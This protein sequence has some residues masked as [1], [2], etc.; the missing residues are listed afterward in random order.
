M[1]DFINLVTNPS[2]YISLAI[3]AASLLIIY[4]IKNNKYLK[5]KNGNYEATF[6][7]EN[8]ETKS[9][10]DEERLKKDILKETMNIQLLLTKWKEDN[11]KEIKQ[12]IDNSFSQQIKFAVMSIDSFISN[13]VN[14]AYAVIIL[15]RITSSAS[16][17]DKILDS[18]RT[19]L[20]DL[21]TREIGKDMK[22]II[23][24]EIRADHFNTRLKEDFDQLV[25]KVLTI[26]TTKLS[27]YSQKLDSEAL[28][29]ITQ[30]AIPE[31]KILINTIL[32]H[33]KK[34]SIETDA[35]VKT[36]KELARNELTMKVK[37]QFPDIEEELVNIIID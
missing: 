4:M 29:K 7:S 36:A 20:M 1:N 33:S 15:D 12:I 22:D 30:K 11:E 25:S 14:E 26:F 27:K 8:R 19:A 28:T 2:F 24:T 9:L 37:I 3:I 32:E 17:N 31:L 16:D 23:C 6:G 35:A 13:D 10:K 18:F 21:L 34:I 5:I